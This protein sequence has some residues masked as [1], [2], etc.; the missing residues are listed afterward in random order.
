MRVQ[1]GHQS[2]LWVSDTYRA[3][4]SAIAGQLKMRY[5]PPKELTATLTDLLAAI[6]TQPSEPGQ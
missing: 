1:S 5:E 3:M 6:D 2:S 4:Q